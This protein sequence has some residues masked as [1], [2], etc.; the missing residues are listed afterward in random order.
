MRGRTGTTGRW[1]CLLWTRHSKN[2]FPGKIAFNT[3]DRVPLGK[4]RVIEAK[5]STNMPSDVLLAQ[6]SEAGAKE[7]A[8]IKVSD[9]MIATLIGGGAFD[10]SPSGPQQQFVSKK[11]LTTWTWVVTPKQS[12]T[13]ILTLSFD[14]VLSV[15]GKDGTRTINTFKRKIEIDVPWPETPSE[16]LVLLKG[17]FDNIHW[18][19]LTILVPL[20]LWLWNKF[21]KKPAA[22]ADE[23]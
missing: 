1:T 15:D 5:L 20:G 9:R 12:G 18:I 2:S 10:V 22:L 17:W 6:L 11:E 13:Q 3:P 23:V 21:R 16:W 19:W 4:S 8:S 14:A 7:S